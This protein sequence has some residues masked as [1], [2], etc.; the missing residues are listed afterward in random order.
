MRLAEPGI[1]APSR[2]QFVLV[3][4]EESPQCRLRGLGEFVDKL[5]DDHRHCLDRRAL[6]EPSVVV[7]PPSRRRALETHAADQERL[8]AASHQHGP[9]GLED[10]L[11]RNAHPT[12][13]L[14]D[15]SVERL[16]AYE[17]VRPLGEKLVDRGVADNDP[18]LL[19]LL[20]QQDGVHHVLLVVGESH[21]GWILPRRSHR[22]HEELVHHLPHDHGPLKAAFPEAAAVPRHRH[23]VRTAGPGV[24][25]EKWGQDEKSEHRHDGEGGER[26]LLVL[27]K[28]TEGSGHGTACGLLLDGETAKA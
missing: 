15:D 9:Q 16:G 21:P 10:V 20:C 18:V 13:D 26:R 22:L 24:H 7:P 19:G 25:L 17:V 1:R 2:R 23:R 11:L 27:A 28:D 5:L 3:L 14:I 4:L 12:P 8:H 6:L